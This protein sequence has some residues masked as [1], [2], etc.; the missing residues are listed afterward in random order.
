MGGMCLGRL[1]LP[2]L[3]SVTRRPLRV[4]AVLDLLIGVFGMALLWGIPLLN[5][6][7]CSNALLESADLV[8]H[9]G[10]SSSTGYDLVVVGTLGDEISPRAIRRLLMSNP[11]LQQPLAESGILGPDDLLNR[12]AGEASDLTDWLQDAQI[13]RDCNCGCNILP[14]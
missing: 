5:R 2:R 6:I 14:A 3:I 12:F 10:A 1:A 11:M 7:D 9:A 8:A 13:N 4:C